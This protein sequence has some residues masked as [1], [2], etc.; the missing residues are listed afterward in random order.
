[1]IE[2]WAIGGYSEIG[3]NMTAVKYKD[4]VIIFD[5]GV[6]VEKVISYEGEAW[7]LNSK[8]LMEIEA[9]PNDNLMRKEWGR[10]VK[11]IV[12]THG[13]LDHIGGITKMA[14]NYP[15][16]PIIATPFTIEVIRNQEKDQQARLKNRIIKLNAGSTYKITN[17][18]KV[19]FVYA[20]HSTLQTVMIALHTPEG[21]IMYTND[22]KFDDNPTFGQ[23]TD[24]KRLRKLG[25]EGVKA[26]ISDSTRID[27]YGRTFSESLVKEMLKDL[28]LNLKHEDKLIVLTTFASHCARI[29]NMV[30]IAKKM[31]RT[32]LILGRSLKNYLEASTRAKLINFKGN[33]ILS[34]KDEIE[35]AFNLIKKNGRDKYLLIMT[36]NQGEPDAMLSRMARNELEIRFN[37]GDIVIFCSETIPT[38]ICQANRSTVEKQLR[39]KGVRLFLDIHVSGH[40]AREDHR[41]LIKMVRPKH[42]IPSHG[43][44][45]KL[46][47]AIEL[48]IE[49][50]YKLGE[51]AHLLQDGQRIK[52][53]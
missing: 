50:G 21:V 34:Y 48:S 15:D 25:D 20:T 28:L 4:E 24:Y 38:P 10:Y 32:P 16:T 14:K 27:V 7:K 18:L 33:R 12:C 31:G 11:A 51:T 35:H 6:D 29:S 3:K 30:E 9:L 44:L 8:R 52:I 47:K 23:K 45:P 49:E 19:E 1:M 40:A 22:W 46:A 13:H 41:D 42:Y 39:E 5:L 43:T 53:E 36:G 26:L 37:K 17:N 2:I